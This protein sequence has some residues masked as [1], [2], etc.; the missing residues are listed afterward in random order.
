MNASMIMSARMIVSTR[1]IRHEG[2]HGRHDG[3]GGIGRGVGCD[4]G[5]T[6]KSYLL[7]LD[8][9]SDAGFPTASVDSIETSL[10]DVSPY[11]DDDDEFQGINKIPLLILI[12]IVVSSG[13]TGPKA[14][15]SL[16]VLDIYLAHK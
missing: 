6:R 7:T 9:T 15:S 5:I 12:L 10:D 11:E 8:Q 4:H 1:R 14:L 2:G 3:R 16:V 13:T